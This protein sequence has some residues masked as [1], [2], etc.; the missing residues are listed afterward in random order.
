[1]ENEVSLGTM[2]L[3]RETK[4]TYVYSREVNGRRETQYVMKSAFEGKPPAKIE[5]VIRY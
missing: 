5:I 1:M 4:N 3:Q 2:T